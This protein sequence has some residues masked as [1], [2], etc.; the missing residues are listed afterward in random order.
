MRQHNG[1]SCP[2]GAIGKPIA[3]RY[4]LPIDCTTRIWPVAETDIRSFNINFG[5]QHLAAHG[6]LRLVLELDGEV[7]RGIGR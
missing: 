7:Y 1:C 3:N 5:P 4:S 6:V 2:P